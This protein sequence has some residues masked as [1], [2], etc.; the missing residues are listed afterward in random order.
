MAVN[1]PWR[2]CFRFKDG[3]AYDVEIIDYHTPVKQKKQ[4]G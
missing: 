2:I 4:R 3:D 1:G